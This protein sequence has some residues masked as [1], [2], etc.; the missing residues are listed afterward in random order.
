MHSHD[1]E[2][3]LACL[4]EIAAAFVFVVDLVTQ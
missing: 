2:S 4:G 3:V 1:V